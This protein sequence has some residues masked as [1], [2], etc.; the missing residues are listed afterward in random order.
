MA[1]EL[2]LLEEMDVINHIRNPYLS[3]VDDSIKDRVRV[4]GLMADRTGEEVLLMDPFGFSVDSVLAGLYPEHME[5]IARFGAKE[6]KEA[7]LEAFTN[8]ETLQRCN[9]VVKAMDMNT[10]SG[11]DTHQKRFLRNV[12]FVI[13]NR[14]A[15]DFK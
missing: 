1:K 7:L 2:N 12:K 9:E 4:A 10:Q 5:Y 3:Y 8:Q 14:I 13:D 11:N 15:F 6:Y